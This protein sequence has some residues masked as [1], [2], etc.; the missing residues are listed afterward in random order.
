MFHRK[1]NLPENH[2]SYPHIW[3]SDCGKFRI[4][5]CTDDLKW[6]V[7][8]YRA[9]KWRSVSYHTEWWPIHMRWAE[10]FPFATLPVE[11]L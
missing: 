9:P 3:K 5:R 4:I 1:I 8:A 10:E 7:Q 6:I 11:T 2:T